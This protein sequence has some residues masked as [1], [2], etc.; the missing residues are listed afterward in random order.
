M[1]NLFSS[2]APHIHPHPQFCNDSAC[3]LVCQRRRT[4][5]AISK[6]SYMV[7]MLNNDAYWGLC[8]RN[9]VILQTNRARCAINK[10]RSDLLK[11]ENVSG[12]R[13]GRTSL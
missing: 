12:A 1:G 2:G 9:F 6:A 7:N 5:I 3:C 8:D 13:S 4:S 11:E 10:K